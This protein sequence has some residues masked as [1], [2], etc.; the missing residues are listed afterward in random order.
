MPDEN[1]IELYK[2]LQGM[3]KSIDSRVLIMTGDILG[4]PTR[5]FLSRTRV[6]YIE[7]PFDTNALLSKLDEIMSRNQ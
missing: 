2:K 5:A 3:D 1:G 6:P 7:K 4:K